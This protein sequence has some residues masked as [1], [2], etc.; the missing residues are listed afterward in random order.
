VCEAL[1]VLAAKVGVLAQTQPVVDAA[2]LQS[3][4]A[5]QAAQAATLTRIDAALTT[6]TATQAAQAATL[7][8]IDAALP[9]LTAALARVDVRSAVAYNASCGN[10]AARAFVPVPNAAG[11]L[12]AVPFA[13]AEQFI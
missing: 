11:A 13:T 3:L 12:P 2:A 6:L 7:T 9:A 10:G 5:T 8:R 1:T 4:A